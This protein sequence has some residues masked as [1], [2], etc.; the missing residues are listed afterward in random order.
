VG[1]AKLALTDAAEKRAREWREV[2]NREAIRQEQTQ[3]RL[4]REEKQQRLIALGA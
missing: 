4:Q 3:K 2:E 1:L